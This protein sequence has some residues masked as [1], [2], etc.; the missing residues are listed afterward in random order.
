MLFCARTHTFVTLSNVNP[1]TQSQD[2]F[3]IVLC[4]IDTAMRALYYT[5]DW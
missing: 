5:A 1:A 4:A 3:V 2:N